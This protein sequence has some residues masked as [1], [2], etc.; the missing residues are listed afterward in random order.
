[1]RRWRRDR[2]SAVPLLRSEGMEWIH[3]DKLPLG[4]LVTNRYSLADRRG[5][6]G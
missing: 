2:F 3:E 6:L 4:K 5:G 1:V